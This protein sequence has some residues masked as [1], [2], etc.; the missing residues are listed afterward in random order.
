MEKALENIEIA[1]AWQDNLCLF[2][3]SMN[4]V[5]L[6][7]GTGTSSDHERLA[8]RVCQRGSQLGATTGVVPLLKTLIVAPSI[9]HQNPKPNPSYL[10]LYLFLSTPSCCCCCYPAVHRRSSSST[11]PQCCSQPHPALSIPMS[12]SAGVVATRRYADIT[13]RTQKRA[14]KCPET[15]AS[16]LV[17]SQLGVNTPNTSTSGKIKHTPV[18]IS[19]QKVIIIHLLKTVDRDQLQEMQERLGRME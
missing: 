2:L 15:R 5:S 4:A 16:V 6:V 7:H 14:S 11:P 1:S 13:I 3:D 10:P 9:P 19:H 12:R 18:S 17:V 8:Q